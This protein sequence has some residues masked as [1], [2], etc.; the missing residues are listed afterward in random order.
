M[1]CHQLL[2]NSFLPNFYC[3]FPRKPQQSF[4]SCSCICVQVQVGWLMPVRLFAFV[5]H[6]IVCRLFSHFW[7]VRPLVRS[8]NFKHGGPRTS[9]A[10]DTLYHGPGAAWLNH[11]N[12]LDLRTKFD[13]FQLYSLNLL[14]HSILLYYN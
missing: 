2:A 8:G 3:L 14:P 13:I 1:P 9:A 12:E 10:C 11:S 7:A 6:L 5:R 4:H